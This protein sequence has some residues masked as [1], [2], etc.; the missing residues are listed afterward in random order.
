[1]R[2]GW[3]SKWKSFEISTSLGDVPIELGDGS[4]CVKDGE[5]ETW[6]DGWTAVE[7]IAEFLVEKVHLSPNEARSVAGEA[8]RRWVESLEGRRHRNPR[9]SN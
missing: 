8:V 7:D 6:C 4:I 5:G 3:G 1:M 2:F 9:K